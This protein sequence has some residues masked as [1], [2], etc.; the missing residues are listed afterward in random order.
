MNY[1]NYKRKAVIRLNNNKPVENKEAIREQLNKD[2]ELYAAAG[3][4][5]EFIP[6]LKTE[7]EAR[8]GL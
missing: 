2:V 5:I 7:Q 6:S 4:K 3:G 8:R 1:M